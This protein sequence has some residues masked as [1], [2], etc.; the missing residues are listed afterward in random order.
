MS[1]RQHDGCGMILKATCNNESADDYRAQFP[2]DR[3]HAIS[4]PQGLGD[5]A[6]SRGEPGIGRDAAG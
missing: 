3:T 2:Y 4:S 5:I 6:A 1:A